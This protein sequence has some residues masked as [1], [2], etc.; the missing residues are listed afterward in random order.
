[1]VSFIQTQLQDCLG[2]HSSGCEP[3]STA[4]EPQWPARLLEIERDSVR[5]IDFNNETMPG[6]YAALSYCWGDPSELE[7]RP[8]FTTKT[9]NIQDLQQSGMAISSLP[10]TIQQALWLCR[11]LD[12]RYIWIDSLCIIQNLPED[13]ERE[14]TKME[15][16]YARSKVTIIAASSTSC[17]SGFLDVRL[18]YTHLTVP[19]NSPFRLSAKV[20]CKSGFHRKRDEFQFISDPIDS[21]GWTVQEELLS[22]RY[23]KFTKDDIQWVCHAQSTCMC[24]QQA[25][26][27][28]TGPW[29]N[30]DYPRDRE[31]NWKRF[32]E[33]LSRRHFTKETD[34]LVA[35]S[36]LA[37]RSAAKFE[38]PEGQAAYI[39]GLWSSN[40]VCQLAWACIPGAVRMTDNYVAPSFSWASLNTDPKGVAHVEILEDTMCKFQNAVT[41]PVFQG[42]EFGA[43]SGGFVSLHGPLIRA[44]VLLPAMEH[45]AIPLQTEMPDFEPWVVFDCPVSESLHPSGNRTLQRSK[46]PLGG[47]LREFSVAVLVLG[48]SEEDVMICLVLGSIE[49]NRYQRIGFAISE[50]SGMQRGTEAFQMLESGKEEVIIV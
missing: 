48:L 9:T 29:Q 28:S 8:P 32:V 23:L 4:D 10:L 31:K 26:T 30:T 39:A 43:I 49:N 18:C 13:W 37:K 2:H 24:G 27:W 22:S 1:M 5:L 41:S 7:S 46:S 35:I 38:V 34:K 3:L 42:N 33:E 14:A 44:T 47:T 19:P 36:S 40:F 45:V 6:Q 11:T 20:R 17:H 15:T 12:I 16:V 25:H 21:R 50:E